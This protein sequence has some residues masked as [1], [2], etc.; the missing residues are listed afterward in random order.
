MV[1]KVIQ[2]VAEWMSNM[3]TKL[4]FSLEAASSSETS[5]N[6]DQTRRMSKK[7]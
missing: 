5:V 2:Q 4:L 6:I 3:A 1:K 7:V